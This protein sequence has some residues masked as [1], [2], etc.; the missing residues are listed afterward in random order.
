MRL[1]TVKY[2]VNEL[3]VSE[4]RVCKTLDIYWSSHRYSVKTTDIEDD[5]VL[6]MTE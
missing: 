1:R 2:V 4:L 6:Q 5:L 3:S